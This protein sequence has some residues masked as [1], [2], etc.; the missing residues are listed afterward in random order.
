MLKHLQRPH[1]N[2]PHH[3]TDLMRAAHRCLFTGLLRLLL[4]CFELTALRLQLTAEL[5]QALVGLQE[6]FFQ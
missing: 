2:P 1:L 5:L 4:C 6:P 3:L